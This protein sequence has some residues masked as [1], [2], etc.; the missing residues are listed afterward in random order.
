MRVLRRAIRIL[1][2]QGL[3]AMLQAIIARLCGLSSRPASSFP[4]C[5]ELITGKRGL[6]IGGPSPVFARGGIF[7]VYSIIGQLDNCNFARTTIWQSDIGLGA[8]YRFDRKRRPGEQY[9]MEATAMENFPAATY[10][11][12]LASHVLEHIANPILA[13]SEWIR[14]LKH[15]GAMVL[16]LPH[17]D[18]T[19]DHRRPIT[20]MEHLIAD[21]TVGTT[22]NDLTHLVEIL[23]LHDLGRDPDAG[24]ME[25]FRERSL[26]NLE[27]RCLHH[28]VFDTA[29]AVNL[30]EYMGLQIHAVEEVMPFHI[31]IVALKPR[32]D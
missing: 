20:T 30:V 21:F 15:G 18:R 19:F 6:E 16:L 23:A 13:L 26:R 12:V 17:R 5:R 8:E 27:N 10:D 11:F 31:L 32:L 3:G 4:L 22:E 29:L 2:T 25:D 14:L 28:H 9:V 7:P 24:D 1:R